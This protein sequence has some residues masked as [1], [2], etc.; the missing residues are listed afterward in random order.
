MG[1]LLVD[2]LSGLKLAWQA[3]KLPERKYD[4]GITGLSSEAT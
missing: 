3:Y 1:L 4:I 2:H